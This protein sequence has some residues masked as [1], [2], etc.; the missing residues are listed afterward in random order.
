MILNQN[1]I[2]HLSSKAKL[3]A[4]KYI[5]NPAFRMTGRELGRIC[6]I[7]HTM[8][9]KILK[10][11]EYINLV[12]SFRAGRSLVWQVKT[13][14]F[15]YKAA[16]ELYKNKSD[17]I[18]VEYFKNVMVKKLPLDIT[19]QAILFG[20]VS[21][22]LEKESSDIDLFVLVKGHKEKEKMEKV[23]EDISE[24]CVRLFGNTLGYYLLTEK[25]LSEREN[26]AVI[27]EIKKGIRLI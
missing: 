26:L 12:F 5:L 8:A 19:K 13:D 17:Y 3:K 6:G 23:L 1:I 9:F 10:E 22:A 14:S 24:E 21:K 20:S 11:F 2:E 27:K 4:L 16:K 7:S 18:P 15:A 25:E